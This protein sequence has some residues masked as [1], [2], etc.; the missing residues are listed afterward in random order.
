MSRRF[1]G[2]AF[3]L[4]KM[5]VRM[6]LQIRE[7]LIWTFVMPL[8]FIYFIGTVTG[9]AFQSG[10][11]Q[12]ALS[13]SAPA[14]AG[15]LAD[16]LVERL[17]ADYRIVPEN[18]D[19]HLEIPGGF[20]ESLLAGKPAKLR[21]VRKG[22]DPG[23]DNVRINRAMY[24]LM[25]DLMAASQGGAPVT[26]AAI[27]AI[28]AEPRNLTLQVKSAGKRALA[29]SGFEQSV[30]GTMV[31]FILLVMFTSGAVTLTIERRGGQLRRLAS[32]PMARG[33]VVLGRWGARMGLGTI[34][35]AFA[36]LAGTVLF[37]I[38]WGRNL[39]MV[40][41]I[42]LSY[43]ALAALLGML[44]GNF[45]RTEGQVI[46]M[47]VLLSNVLAGLGGCWWPIEITPKWA[48]HAAMLLP[49]GWTMDALHKLV[50]FGGSPSEVL[51]H[52]A[53]SVAGCAVTGWIVSRCFR[54]A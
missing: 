43:G 53:A 6:Q 11:S 1:F 45:G 47:G 3:F 8:V 39:P 32:T 26:R 30:P 25:G 5:G 27:E 14:D 42:L 2:D 16:V 51:P 9:H 15:F 36:M 38:H 12:D 23:I 7:I 46:G 33:S 48:Q 17:G 54:F 34:Q 28:A 52:L 41:V 50:N 31:M 4:A 29:P 49:T 22:D 44:L 24:L 10:G 40:V 18:T 37:H 13:V 35:I 21:F 19:R 20:T